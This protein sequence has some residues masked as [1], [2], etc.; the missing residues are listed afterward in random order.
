MEMKVTLR[1]HVANRLVSRKDVTEMLLVTDTAAGPSWLLVVEQPAGL[2]VPCLTP[3]FPSR[4][5]SAVGVGAA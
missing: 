4:N 3:A 1:G 5:P 2:G